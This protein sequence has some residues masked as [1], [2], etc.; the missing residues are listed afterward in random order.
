MRYIIEAIKALYRRIAMWSVDPLLTDEE[1]EEMLKHKNQIILFKR[2]TK[3][4]TK[5]N[6]KSDDFFIRIELEKV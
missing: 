6:D 4:I 5:K 1:T 3:F 2:N